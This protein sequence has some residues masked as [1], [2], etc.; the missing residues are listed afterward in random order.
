[1]KEKLSETELL[2]SKIEDKIRFC[3]SKNKIT[4]TDFLTMPEKV[5]VE[6]HLKA[7]HIKNYFFFGARENPDREILLF[8][9]EKITED[10]ARKN[11]SNIL[12]GIRIS[13]PSSLKGTFEHRDYLSGIMKLGLVREKL[14][15]ILVY[16]DG[17]DF[18]VLKDNSQYLKDNLLLLTRFKKS[19]I[20]IIDISD[21][22]QI[23]NQFETFTIIINSMRADNIISEVIHTSRNKTEEIISDERAT[24]NYELIE[25]GSKILKAN[26][27]L[28]IKGYGK[29]IIGDLIRNTSSGKLV[30]SIKKAA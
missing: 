18:I 20:E 15:D 1:M 19:K 8:Y 5:K 25:K 3:N 21:I 11:L 26:D 2:L 29:F 9:P 6:K 14:G 4:Y 30:I 10:L 13:L 23:E 12:T 28:V 27:I 24:L 7:L 16:E 17:A 22:K